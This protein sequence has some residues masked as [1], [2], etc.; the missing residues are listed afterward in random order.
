MTT[1]PSTPRPQRGFTLIEILIAV[2]LGLLI[3]AGLARLFV[4]SRQTFATT[5]DIS[6]MQENVRLAMDVLGRT[7]RAAGYMSAPNTYALPTDG[8]PGV[9]TFAPVL[10]IP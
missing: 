5:D 1:H 2:A 9:F 8:Y 4:G 6:R 7:V 3:T 10:S